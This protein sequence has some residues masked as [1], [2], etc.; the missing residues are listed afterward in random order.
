MSAARAR[1]KRPKR[2]NGEGTI[3]GPRKDGRYVGAL[4]V[5]TTSG[6]YKRV[7]V[8]GRTWE[9][10]HEK[11]IKLQATAAGGTPVAAESWKVGPYLDHWLETVVKTA[12]RPATYA[13]YEMTVRLYLKP[14]LG[15]Y[16]LRQLSV[17]HVQRF[18]NAQLGAAG[19]CGTHT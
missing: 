7:Y 8:Y 14:G 11:L 2:H 13:L 17:Y 15:R 9:Q 18:L 10:A 6:A 3:S 19:R 4:S 5:M 16:R 1:R 12:R